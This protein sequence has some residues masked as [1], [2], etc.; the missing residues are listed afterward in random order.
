MGTKTISCIHNVCLML[1]VRHLISKGF[2]LEW[3]GHMGLVEVV[4]GI[5]G[6]GF[7]YFFWLLE[8]LDGVS[9]GHYE[10]SRWFLNRFRMES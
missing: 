6:S 5:Y 1:L 4:I 3:I 2:E 10:D 9:M 8:V 7:W